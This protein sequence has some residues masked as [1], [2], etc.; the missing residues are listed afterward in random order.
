MPATD[1]SDESADNDGDAGE[2]RTITMEE[3]LELLAQAAE[4]D[5]QI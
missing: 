2:C 1:K 4:G 3:L 5:G